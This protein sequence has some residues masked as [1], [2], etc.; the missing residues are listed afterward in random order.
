MKVVSSLALVVA[1]GWVSMGVAAPKQIVSIPLHATT[2]NAGHIAQ[3]TL[4]PLG[5]DTKLVLF[6]GGVPIGTAIP[7]HLYTYIYS[8]SCAR[9]ESKPAWELNEFVTDYFNEQVGIKLW[10][11]VPV[12]YDSLR[13][14][15]YALVVRAS[16]ADG[17]QD[18][19]CGELS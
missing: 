5:S 12:A 6:V 17:N 11:S 8:G 10:K 1:V 7:A 2:Y 16:P 3:A 13:S 9:H 19:F 4:T 14:G 15:G 18:I